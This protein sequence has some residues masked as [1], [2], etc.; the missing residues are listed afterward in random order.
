MQILILIIEKYNQYH[1]NKLRI[2]KKK[3][4]YKNIIIDVQQEILNNY[5]MKNKLLHEYYN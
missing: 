1:E 2:E 3:I 4:E 5:I